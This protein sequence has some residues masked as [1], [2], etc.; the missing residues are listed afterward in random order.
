MTNRR[1]AA[2]LAGL[3]AI[4]APAAARA[5]V[6]WTATME[7]GDLSE[8]TSTTNGTKALDG[9]VRKNIEASTD[10]AYRGQY[11][12]KVT[13]HPDDDFGQYHQDRADI[14]HDSTLTGE[15]KDSYLSGYYFLPEDAKTRDEI[16]F[17]ETKVTSRNWMDLWLEPK[18]GGGTTV[19]FGIESN[20]ANLGSVLVWTGE[21][22]AG[23]WHQF[24]I[25]VHW[26]TDATKGMVDL[27]LDGQPVVASYKHKTKFDTNDMFFQTGLHRVLTQPYTETIYFDDFIESDTLA[28]AK[29]MAP[30]QPSADGGTNLDAADATGAGGTT[31]AAGTTG[32]A[33]STGAAGTTGAGGTTGAAGTTGS[34]GATGSAGTTGSAGAAGATGAGGNRTHSSGGCA[35]ATDRAS[36]S[37]LA[38]LLA[39][40]GTVIFR[41]KRWN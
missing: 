13:V 34:A 10:R 39:L 22:K 20:G 4:A 5:T 27:W 1:A 11:S 9:G 21:W 38:S 36:L 12:C 23:V 6:V 25:H 15:G 19:K 14:K 40:I 7:K 8:W 41:R 31:G 30:V 17:Y 32:N 24:A 28:E 3:G 37:S 18:S 2:A 29:I 16:A 33:G 26:S 35:I